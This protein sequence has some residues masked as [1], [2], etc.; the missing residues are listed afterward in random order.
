MQTDSQ[1]NLVFMC[2][3]CAACALVPEVFFHHKERREKEAA[4]E[5]LWLRA[6]RISPDLATIVIHHEID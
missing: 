4:R 6:M 3:D 5:N 2:S 1:T